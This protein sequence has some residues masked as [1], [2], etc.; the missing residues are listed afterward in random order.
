MLKLLQ[1]NEN[2]QNKGLEMNKIM[3]SNSHFYNKDKGNNNTDRD[4][5]NETSA[6]GI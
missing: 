6:L 1:K 5:K 3:A 4:D 2:T